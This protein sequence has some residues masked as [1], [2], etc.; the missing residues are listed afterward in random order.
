MIAF[1]FP[2]LISIALI[3]PMVG[4]RLLAQKHG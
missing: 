3:V 2:V 4:L 1:L